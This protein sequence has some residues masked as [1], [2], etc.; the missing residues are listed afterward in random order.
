M[1]CLYGHPIARSPLTLTISSSDS[2]ADFISCQGNGFQNA[3]LSKP[4]QEMTECD[5]MMPT[6][7]KPQDPENGSTDFSNNKYDPPDVVAKLQKIEAQVNEVERKSVQGKQNITAAE[8]TKADQS[9]LEDTVATREDSEAPRQRTRTISASGKRMITDAMNKANRQRFI[10]EKSQRRREGPSFASESDDE[11]V[12]KS[13]PSLQHEKSLPINSVKDKNGSIAR[14]NYDGDTIETEKKKK[15]D[16]SKPPMPRRL[17]TPISHGDKKVLSENAP[18]NSL[19]PSQYSLPTSTS[20][21]PGP[22]EKSEAKFTYPLDQIG[23][24]LG[25]ASKPSKIT[26]TLKSIARPGQS[27]KPINILKEVSIIDGTPQLVAKSVLNIKDITSPIG[28]T[29]LHNKNFVI[30]NPSDDSVIMFNPDGKLLSRIKSIRPFKRP[31]DMATLSTGEFVA[32]DDVGLQLFGQNGEF[33]KVL[34]GNEIDQCFGVS[35]DEEGRILTINFN[36]QKGKGGITDPGETDI[37]FI[38]PKSGAV[39]K[40]IELTDIISNKLKSKCRFLNYRHHTIYI[41]DLGLDNIYKLTVRGDPEASIIG[42]T[43]SGPGQLK[44]PAGLVVDLYGNFIVADSLNHR[45]QI[46]NN[47]G[48]YVGLVKVDLPVNR[49]SGIYLDQD[50]WELYVLNYWGN[51]MTK[52]RIEH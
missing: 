13:H 39:V 51:S 25:I 47:I 20:N 16:K 9:K 33:V 49:P 7:V 28:I 17:K 3:H 38:C 10:E 5:S 27:S 46:F 42:R 30:S 32:R 15:R 19:S 24:N 29:V 35:E 4:S 22:V 12:T 31:T 6:P 37:F 14:V 26:P 52:Y 40:R 43:G 34:G 41:V 8:H 36:K 48:N 23:K 21:T 50:L 11:E 1:A 44:D 45:L 18:T 2:Q